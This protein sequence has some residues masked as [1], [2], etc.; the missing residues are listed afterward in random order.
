MPAM[1]LPEDLEK[2]IMEGMD[3][4]L[5]SPVQQDATWLTS[6]VGDVHAFV[7]KH[8]QASDGALVVYQGTPMRIPTI[9]PAL[10]ET[11]C[12]FL[13]D[14]RCT[15]WEYAPAGC[16]HYTV[17]ESAE[18]ANPKSQH[19][20]R[21]CLMA[22]ES[23]DWYARVWRWLHEWGKKPPSLFERREKLQAVLKQLE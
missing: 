12:V 19:I 21:A 4:A 17:H 3:Q 7:E 13:Q 10:T 20:L 15:I 16:S 22:F 9:V 14:A 23:D 8:F 1:L 6:A 11:G 18:E 5:L 2:I